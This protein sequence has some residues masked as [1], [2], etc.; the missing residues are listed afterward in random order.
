MLGVGFEV[1]AG[2]LVLMAVFNFQPLRP[3]LLE[4]GGL[5]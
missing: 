4:V 1:V 3:T 2:A 5:A